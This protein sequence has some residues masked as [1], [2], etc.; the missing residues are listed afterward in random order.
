MSIKK[1]VPHKFWSPQ[2]WGESGWKGSIFFSFPLIPLNL[3]NLCPNISNNSDISV[4]L[5]KKNSIFFT[6]FSTK[7]EER[8]LHF[9]LFSLSFIF[10][11]CLNL[12][13]YSFSHYFLSF[14]QDFLST[15]SFLAQ[16]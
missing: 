8:E 7:Q 2:S 3:N 13:K 10:L 9:S 11:S 5:R 6:F 12:K 15:F 16:T 1:K 4:Y 14:Y